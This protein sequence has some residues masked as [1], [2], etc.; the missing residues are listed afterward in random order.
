M[1]KYIDKLEFHNLLK[2]Y[3]ETNSRS[4]YEKI[5]G[6]FL[7]IAQNYL[8][9]PS[10][11][12]YSSDW[13]DDMVSE[14]VL[15]MVRYI[16]NYDVDRMDLEYSQKGKIPDPFSYFSQY[17][18]NGIN[19]LLKERKKDNILVRLPFIENMDKREFSYE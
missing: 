10:Y 17:A 13:K 14:A 9:K 3:K 15:D 1:A 2:L 7:L 4:A 6:F 16:H 5:G 12:N 11:I 19:R 8:N 18:R